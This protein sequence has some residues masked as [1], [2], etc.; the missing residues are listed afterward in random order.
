MKYDIAESHVFDK[1]GMTPYEAVNRENLH[2]VLRYS[3]VR[4]IQLDERNKEMKRRN[5]QKK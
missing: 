5:K 2:N 4:A 1:Q 3:N